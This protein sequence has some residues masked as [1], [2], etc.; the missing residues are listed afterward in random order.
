M[1]NGEGETIS[2]GCNELQ[3][4]SG[5]IISPEE[6]NVSQEKENEK[7]P[8]ITPSTVV[9]KKEIQKGETQL[10]HKILIRTQLYPLRSPKD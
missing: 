10:N 2:V 7:Q 4:R 3:L 6:N 9:I 1:E 5:C 8:A